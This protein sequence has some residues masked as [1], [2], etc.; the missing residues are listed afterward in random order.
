MFN[1]SDALCCFMFLFSDELPLEYTAAPTLIYPPSYTDQPP[2]EYSNEPPPKYSDI[3]LFPSS[4]DFSQVSCEQA[5]GQSRNTDISIISH[6]KENSVLTSSNVA[7]TGSFSI[8]HEHIGIS[9]VNTEALIGPRSTDTSSLAGSGQNSTSIRHGVNTVPHTDHWA[10]PEQ[11]RSQLRN[12]A[13][14]LTAPESH[15]GNELLRGNALICMAV[16]AIL[17]CPFTGIFAVYHVYR[18][19]KFL[20]REERNKARQSA[21]NAIVAILWSFALFLIWFMPLCSGIIAA[22]YAPDVNVGDLY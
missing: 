11:R 3:H 13:V 2:L 14:R 21:H 22:K 6:P 4:H 7:Y 8:G 1:F 10:Y 9:R 16:C 12:T 20:A 18:K 5:S 17:W 19:H 15:G